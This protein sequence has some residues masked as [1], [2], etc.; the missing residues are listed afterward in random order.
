MRKYN[1][2]SGYTDRGAS[3]CRLLFWALFCLFVF[4]LMYAAGILVVFEDSSWIIRLG[5]RVILGGCFP[6]GLCGL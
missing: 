4:G 6:F 2:E 5:G 1:F 3:V